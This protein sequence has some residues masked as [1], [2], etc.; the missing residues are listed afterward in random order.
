LNGYKQGM[1]NNT[2]KTTQSK[3][4]DFEDILPPMKPFKKILGRQYGYRSSA[5]RA[6][7]NFRVR[8][9]VSIPKGYQLWVN[10]IDNGCYEIDGANPLF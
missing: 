1:S 9:F 8:Y 7:L 6:I 4:I 2:T 5:L 10:K 3:S